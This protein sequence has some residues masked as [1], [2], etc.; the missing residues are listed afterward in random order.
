MRTQSLQPHQVERKW[1][2]VDATG[3][4]LGRL[5]SRIATILRGKHRPTYTP[6]ADNGD[7]VVVVNAEKVR[8]TG[9]KL[10]AKLYQ[11]H[12]GY[13]GGF[14]AEPY[15]HL[16][17]RMPTLA[18][19]K[20]VRGMLPKTKL[21]RRMRSKLKVYAGPKHPHAAQKPQPLAL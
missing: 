19:E 7:F 1:H 16:L 18:I 21:G 9:D 20:A 10:N 4:P 8:L 17:Q 2:V 13:P 15:R 12:S 6:N 11:R 5:A 3:V 14:K